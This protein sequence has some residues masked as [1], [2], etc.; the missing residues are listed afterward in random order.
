MGGGM[1]PP[2]YDSF[3]S[4]A[5]GFFFFGNVHQTMNTA[6]PNA[7][8]TSNNTQAIALLFRRFA[9]LRFAALICYLPGFATFILAAL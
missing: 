3:D 7:I 1:C 8:N 4:S 2:C 5:L 6:T 9:A